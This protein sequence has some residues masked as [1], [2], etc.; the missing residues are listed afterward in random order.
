M[1]TFA[2]LL[3]RRLARDPGRPLLTFYDEATG[4][5][6]ELSVTTYANWVAKTA[7]FLV[8]ECELERGDRLRVDLPPHWLGPVFL[9][10]AWLAGVVVV[11][12]QDEEEGEAWVVTGPER[13]DEAVSRHPGRVIACALHPLGL[14]FDRPLPPG[15]RDFGAEV[16][17]QPDSFVPWDPPADTDQAVPGTTQR[18]LWQSAAE[19]P[20]VRDEGRLL[21]TSNPASPA[22][23]RTF[24]APF[25]RAGSLV[26]VRNAGPQRLD[27]LQAAERVTVRLSPEDQPTRS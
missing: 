5:R 22:G 21:T 27:R 7:S 19:D 6:T 15:V 12:D 4:E 23:L 18:Q 17:S 25:A 2:D 9:G 1:T 3:A 8:E 14:R 13:L 16:W 26:L 24:V 20:A 10:A 11:L